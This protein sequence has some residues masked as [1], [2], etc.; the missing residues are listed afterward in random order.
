MMK[1]LTIGFKSF[2]VSLLSI[3]VAVLFLFNLN[4]PAYAISFPSRADV[5]ATVDQVQNNIDQFIKQSQQALTQKSQET[6]TAI[7]TL[8]DNLEA[9]TAELDSNYRKAV[10]ADLQQAQQKLE[11][12]AQEYEQYA[13]QADALE[14]EMLRSAQQSRADMK[15]GAQQKAEDV[16]TGVQ[17]K[18]AD[19]K[20]SLRLTSDAINVLVDDTKQAIND[21]ASFSK[22]RVT[23]HTQALQ[24]ALDTSDQA[25]KALFN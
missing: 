6:R 22:A 8:P 13:Q 10:L 7:K 15:A 14:Q 16:Q 12:T 20:E 3:L 4:V 1:F 2:K 25:L 21:T 19:V 23:Q 5:H 17:Q 9:A 11:K 24:Q 18:V